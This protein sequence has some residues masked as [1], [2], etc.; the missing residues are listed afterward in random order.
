M[1]AWLRENLVCPHHHSE[2]S[3]QDRVL[4]CP[5]Q[6]Q[7]PVVEGVPVMLL[8]DVAQTMDL[9][10][11]SLR[12]SR[13][14]N[15]DGGL[16]IDS[17]G[18][19]D[20]EKRAILELAK[21]TTSRIDAVVSFLVGA[22]N[23][24]AYAHL[25]GRLTD[26]PIPELR[27]PQAQ[28]QVFL[29][30]GCNWGRWCF[31]ASRRG[32]RAVGIDP[33]LGAVMAARRVAQQLGIEATFLVGDARFL[34]FKP[35][36]LD[37]VFSYSVLQHFSRE[38]VAQALREVGRTLKT[39]GSSLV[40]MPTKF[41]VRCLQHQMRRGFREGAN[42]EVRYW[43][44]PALRDLFSA[45][46]GASTF[47]VDCFFGIGLQFSDMHL[48]PPGQKIVILMSELLRLSS[49]LLRPL[50]WVADSVYVR[51]VKTESP[52]GG[53]LTHGQEKISR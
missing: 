50:V 11:T 10:Q 13:S 24:N 48:M 9:A 14:P 44:I 45:T 42:F 53:E 40:Q 19:T 35:A 12:Q 21:T 23:G 4:V 5:F 15:A 47:S 29:D 7:Y 37:H 2:L 38:D 22:T 36:S 51:S 31:A 26:Y 34:P 52:L 49:Q 43:S 20:T 18:L 8:D 17:L 3:W 16:Y 32:Y 30:L 25:I 1:N 33:S 6:C 28:G 39:G 27:M 46:I 41:G